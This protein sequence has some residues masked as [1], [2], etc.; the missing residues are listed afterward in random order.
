MNSW[1]NR[2]ETRYIHI[3]PSEVITLIL[4]ECPKETFWNLAYVMISEVITLILRE[5]PKNVVKVGIHHVNWGNNLNN[6]W[7]PKKSSEF[8]IYHVIWSNNENINWMPKQIFG[9]VSTHTDTD[10]YI[11]IYIY[12]HTH[13][14]TDTQTHIY[15]PLC[16]M[17]TFHP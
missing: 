5:C 17:N 13:T 11:Y 7:I 10:T 6:N 1:N 8:G 3:I 9:K 14:E 4:T 2:N 15:T 16:Y 12:T